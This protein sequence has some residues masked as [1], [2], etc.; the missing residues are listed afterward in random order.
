MGDFPIPKPEN[1]VYRL[2]SVLMPAQKSR[3]QALF[4]SA[5]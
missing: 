4:A 1:N 5:D 3:K 2:D